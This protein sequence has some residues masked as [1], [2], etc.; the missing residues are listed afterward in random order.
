M[1]KS[2]TPYLTSTPTSLSYL[3]LMLHADPCFPPL[4]SPPW[5]ATCC[6]DPCWRARPACLCISKPA[7]TFPLLWSPWSS[8]W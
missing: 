2:C 3:S 1:S 7:M 5:P 6:P 4:P 8:A